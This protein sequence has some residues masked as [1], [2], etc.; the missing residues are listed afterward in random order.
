M[1]QGYVHVEIIAS[2][3]SKKAGSPCGDVVAY[4]RTVSSTTMVVS[5][6]IGSGVKAHIAAQ[7]CVSRLLEL[8]RQG[9]SL[10]KAFESVV[11]TM[12][13]AKGTDLPYAVF[14]VVRILS[15]GVTTVLT[16]EM[17]QPVLVTP[18]YA[19]V[20]AQRSVTMAGTLTGE[21][22]C[23]VDSGEG[24]VIVSDGITQAGLGVGLANGWTIEGAS[25]YIN[26]CLSSGARV[27]DVPKCLL[28]QAKQVWKTTLG[29]DCTVALAACRRGKTVNILTGPPSNRMKDQATIKR[30][31]TM[32]G[33]KVVCG[34]TTSKIVADFL[35]TE[36][37]VELDKHSTLCPAR[38]E[39]KGIDLVTEGA[40]TLNQVY[41]IFDE[42]PDTFD[43]I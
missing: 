12:E 30:F 16:Y 37:K 31:L 43:E 35:G 42:D 20:L 10:R 36:V 41:N 7:M 1:D 27:G 9:Y 38:Y 8:F 24:I 28:S 22:N 33:A 34:G 32:E 26:D 14:S 4:E 11:K 6:G 15:D 21:S 19:Q 17:P 39:I 3:S 40:V 29:D 13:Q 5:D 18:R 2:Q 23:H 25:Q